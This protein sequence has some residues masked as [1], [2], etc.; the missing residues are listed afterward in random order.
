MKVLLSIRPEYV[1]KIFSGEKK[2]E[3]RKNIFKKEIDKVIVYSTQPEGKIVGEFSVEIIL[4]DTLDNIWD[5]TSRYSGISHSFFK[6][7]FNGREDGYAIKIGEVIPYNEPIDPRDINT[8]F[9]PPQS[10]CY[11]ENDFHRH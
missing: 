10:F 11:L 9:K 6:N 5:L 2:Y 3:Y 1:E 7:Y 4:H 8:D